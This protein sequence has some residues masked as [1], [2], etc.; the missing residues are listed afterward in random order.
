MKIT[1]FNPLIVSGKRDEYQ[2]LFEELG[3]EKRHNKVSGVSEDINT[4]RMKDANGFHIDLTH[5]PDK[6]DDMMIIRMNVDDLDEAYNL[7]TSHDF[8][9]VDGSESLTPSS[10]S[11][12]MQAPSGFYID[13]VKHIK[14]HD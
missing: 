14:D 8:K 10:K 13:I 2:K 5:V 3:F 7:L 11:V 4:I 9:A 12:L 6:E 1:S